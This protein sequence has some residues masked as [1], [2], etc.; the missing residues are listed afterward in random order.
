MPGFLLRLPF[1]FGC[2]TLASECPQEAIGEDKAHFKRSQSAGSGMTDPVA[3]PFWAVAL[4]VLFAAIGV[5]Q[6]VFAP[7]VRW[8]FRR[9]FNIAIDELNQ[10]LDMRIQPFRLTKRQTLIDRLIHDPRV[11]EAVEAE[12]I[13]AGTPR[14]VMMRRAERYAREIVPALSVTTYFGFG[15]RAARRLSEFVYRVRLGYVDDAALK[16]LDPDSTVVFVMNHRSNMDYVLVTYM[17]SN[18]ASL[19]YAVGEWARVWLLQSLIRSMGACFIRRESGDELYRKVLGRYVAMA[20]HEGVTQAMFPEGGLTRDG[21]LRE[22]RLGLLSY[23]VSGFDPKS[24]RDIVFVPVGLNYDRVIEDRILT[25]KAE[26]EIT[27]RNFRVRAASI[28]GF[29][30]RL[31]RLR[32]RGRLYRFGY[33][34]V[35]FGHPVS[36]AAWRKRKRVDF[37]TSDREKLFTGVEKLADDLMDAVGAIV[38]ALPVALASH[39]FLES[40]ERWMSE[41]EL[42]SAFLGLMKRLE[43]D[44]AHVHIPRADR[45]YAVATGLRMLTLRHMVV[46]NDEWLY[47]ANPDETLLLKYYA[48]SIAHLMK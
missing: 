32:L 44:G 25:S 42:K 35:S 18:R 10:R 8:F 31:I 7:S 19:S 34:C 26:Q 38:P 37:T 39:V 13:R 40:G 3:L 24:S 45:D 14:S 36:L 22:P 17:A 6:N 48:N 23:M 27:G 43:A 4:L 20:T 15:I 12:A 28:L 46:T 1:P 5:F 2:E 9:R 33:A 21:L 47:R 16:A 29:F 41:F 30:W 11:M